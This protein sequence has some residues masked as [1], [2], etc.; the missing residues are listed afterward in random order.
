MIQ[1]NVW[2]PVTEQP[3]KHDENLGPQDQERLVV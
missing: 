2:M 3:P 1:Y